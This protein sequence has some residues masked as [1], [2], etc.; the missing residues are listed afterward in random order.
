IW[1]A[2]L[3]AGKVRQPQNRRTDRTGRVPRRR[4]RLRGAEETSL[5]PTFRH[6]RPLQPGPQGVCL[7][8]MEVL[9]GTYLESLPLIKQAI[10]ESDFVAIDTE[11]TGGPQRGLEITAESTRRERRCLS[12]A[13]DGSRSPRSAAYGRRQISRYD[14]L[15]LRYSKLRDAAQAF[16]VVQFGLAAFRYEAEEGSGGVAGSPGRWVSRTF[17]FYIFTD[18]NDE[19]SGESAHRVFSC[20]PSSLLFLSESG[21]D[22]NKL[23]QQGTRRRIFE[24]SDRS[25]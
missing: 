2:L 22:F 25:P 15:G 10:E 7:S 6:G 8:S 13:G 18:E 14:D 20:Q 4:P 12:R 16:R 5:P 3:S 23:L 1:H 24:F 11:F 19:N 9:R 17:N 21:F